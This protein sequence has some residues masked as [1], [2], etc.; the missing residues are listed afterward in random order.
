MTGS[1]EATGLNERLLARDEQQLHVA[2][3]QSSGTRVLVRDYQAG[4]LSEEEFD[5][6]FDRQLE[7]DQGKT[8]ESWSRMEVKDVT[9]ALVCTAIGAG[10]LSLP[11]AMAQ[12]GLIIGRT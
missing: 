3:G 1:M 6:A 7:Y 12:S 9:Y 2:S 11:Y 5:Q 4:L 10:V 8:K